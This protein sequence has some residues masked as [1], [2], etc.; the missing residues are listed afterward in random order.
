M[1]SIESSGRSLFGDTCEYQR[2][3]R[4]C[5]GNK[6]RKDNSPRTVGMHFK[7]TAWVPVALLALVT[8]FLLP[9][10]IVGQPTAGGLQRLEKAAHHH[11]LKGQ[12]GT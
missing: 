12:L 4:I 8:D 11:L 1:Q 2:E 3:Q 9:N 5:E 10:G 6:R 7:H